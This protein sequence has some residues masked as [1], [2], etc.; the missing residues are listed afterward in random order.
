MDP[1]LIDTL[2]AQIKAKSSNFYNGVE[3]P[4]ARQLAS[5]VVSGFNV[6]SV[7]DPND[8]LGPGGSANSG[9]TS[10]NGKQRQDAIIGVVSAL[11]AV[12]ILV[13]VFLVFRSLKRRRELAHRRLSDPPDAYI[14]GARPDGREFDQDSIGGQRRRSFYFAE[15]SLRDTP[16]QY[17]EYHE[18]NRNSPSPGG[19]RE[20]RVGPGAISAPVL[21]A[22]SMNW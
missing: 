9:A 1:E 6:R 8:P 15:D 5:H 22:S 3:W 13:L 7:T 4:A 10:N 21:Q 16:Q 12:A 11:G 19:M 2:A 20:R 18:V 14:V 17:G